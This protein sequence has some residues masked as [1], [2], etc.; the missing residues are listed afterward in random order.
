MK[1]GIALVFVAALFGAPASVKVDWKK[2]T[3]ESKSTAHAASGLNPPLR[4]GSAIHDRVFEELRKLGADYVRYVL[5]CLTRSW[6]WRS[7]NRP[8]TVKRFGIS[9]SSTRWTVDSWKPPRATRLF[10]NFSTIPQWM[11][12]NG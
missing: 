1:L 5:G 6:R 10:S 7:S 8:E 4:R 2:V 9:R 11:F 3:G 12:K